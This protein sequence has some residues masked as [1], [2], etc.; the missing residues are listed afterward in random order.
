MH[1]HVA[2]HRSSCWTDAYLL[3]HCEGFRVVS[4]G[5]HLGYVEEVVRPDRGAAPLS[6]IVRRAFG[7]DGL[8]SIPLADVVELRPDGGSIVVLGQK[9]T[10]YSSACALSTPE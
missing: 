2:R 3:E 7:A 4:D 1:S 6:L 9:R 10:T 5:V 8:M